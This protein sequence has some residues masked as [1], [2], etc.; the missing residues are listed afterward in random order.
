M[1]KLIRKAEDSIKRI[2]IRHRQMDEKKRNE[3]L[4]MVY[5]FFDQLIILSRY[6]DKETSREAKMMAKKMIIEMNTFFSKPTKI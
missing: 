5:S 6:P 3:A 2:L 1:E 4:S